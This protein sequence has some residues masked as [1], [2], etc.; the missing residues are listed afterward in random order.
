MRR[1]DVT[2]MLPRVPRRVTGNLR[3]WCFKLHVPGEMNAHYSYA[4][5]SMGSLRE[6]IQ[7]G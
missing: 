3:G 1:P 5:A 2:T 4:R 7:A 6:A